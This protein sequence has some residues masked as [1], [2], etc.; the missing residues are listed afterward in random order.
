MISGNDETIFKLLHYFI[1]VKNYNPVILHGVKDEIWLENLEG[2]YKIIRLV[3]NYIHNNEQLQMDLYKTNRIVK[4]IKKKT[5]SFNVPILSIMLN[6][7]ENVHINEDKIGDVTFVV[8]KELKDIT[9]NENI[10]FTFPDLK[11][12]TNFKEKGIELFA[13]IT[14]DINKKTEKDT[15]QAEDIFKPKKP[16]ITYVLILINVLVFLISI[17]FDMKEEVILYGGNHRE[18]IRLGDYYRLITSMFI[19]VDL[20]HLLCNCYSLYVV[21][22]QIESFF[23]KT[24]YLIIYFGSGIIAS[25]LSICF[26]TSFSIGA[27]G[28]IFGLLGS[29]LYFGYHYRLYL[30][31]VLKTQIIPLIILN[32]LIGFA[33]TGID[34]AAHIGGLIGGIL[35]SMICGLKYK[36]NKVERFNGILMTIILLSVIIYL[37]IFGG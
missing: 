10:I 27:S 36:S 20:L 21:G 24:K 14:N 4:S 17:L 37:G 11:N 1:T 33:S 13:K 29:I 12:H 23:G 2:D 6:T 22:N 16:V 32:L 8:G 30:G 28:A 25:L 3:S 15:I 19:H 34:N 26:N 5:L 31:N 18:L 7:G 35:V 9:D